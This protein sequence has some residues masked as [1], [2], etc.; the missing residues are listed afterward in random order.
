MT[1]KSIIRWLLAVGVGIDILLSAIFGGAPGQTIS[2]RLGAARE[3]GSIVAAL[4]CAPLEW[5]DRGHCD[6]ASK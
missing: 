3:G 6:T 4:A 2:A 1:R 5:I